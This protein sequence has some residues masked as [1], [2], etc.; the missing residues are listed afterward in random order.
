MCNSFIVNIYLPSVLKYT[1]MLLLY[2]LGN[3]LYSHLFLHHGFA[4]NIAKYKAIYWTF[5]LVGATAATSIP[6]TVAYYFKQRFK[7]I[8]IPALKNKLR[9]AYDTLLSALFSFLS[10]SILMLPIVFM[11]DLAQFKTEMIFFITVSLSTILLYSIIYHTVLYART[12]IFLGVNIERAAKEKLEYNIQYL[13]TLFKPQLILDILDRAEAA[14][15]KNEDD[16]K[17]LIEEFSRILQ[18]KIYEVKRRHTVIE[19]EINNFSKY[20]NLLNAVYNDEITV[21]ITPAKQQFQI[22][23]LLLMTVLDVLISDHATNCITVS[24]H[25]TTDIY[26]IT[27]N[28]SNMTDKRKQNALSALQTICCSNTGIHSVKINEYNKNIT[29]SICLDNIQE[30]S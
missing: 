13:H 26:T 23:P 9:F 5:L 18:Y 14:S 25:E 17:Q 24:A 27:F 3:L 7:N 22:K 1:S 8:K 29:C 30:I 28:A 10:I 19:T 11:V 20:V 15:Q 12:Y 6:F 16:A 2:L 21:S 4:D